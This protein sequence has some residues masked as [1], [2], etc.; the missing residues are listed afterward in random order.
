MNVPC[1]YIASCRQLDLDNNPLTLRLI[2][3]EIDSDESEVLITTFTDSNIFSQ[4]VFGE[5]YHKRWL[6]E[7]GYK[8][9][10]CRLQLEKITGK[11]VLSVYKDIHAKV[12]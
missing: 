6:F 4:D 5:L 12:F 7:E 3:V 9:I 1:S 8:I 2:R 11:T 10:T